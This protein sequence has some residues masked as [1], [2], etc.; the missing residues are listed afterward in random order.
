MLEGKISFAAIDIGSNAVRLL[1]KS[2][3]AGESP[4]QLTKSLLVRVPLR[5]GEDSFTKG[6]ISSTKE[7]R[8]VRLIKS[9]S[10][11]M[12]IYNVTDYR[13][14]ATSAMRDARNGKKIA[15]K[16]FDKTGIRL[17]VIDGLEEARIVYDSHIAD[18][19]SAEGSYLYVDVGGGSTEVSLISRGELLSSHSYNIGTVRALNNRV[20]QE[21]LEAINRD[22]DQLR[23]RYPHLEIIGSGGNINKLYRLSADKK[24][25]A[26]NH[27]SVDHLETLYTALKKLT[28]NERMKQFKLNPDRADVIIPASEIFLN[29][30]HRVGAESIIVPTIG[31]IDGLTHTL[32]TQYLNRLDNR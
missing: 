25:S 5:L 24:A 12:K 19:L 30:A 17:E 8:L 7:K 21:D 9:F 28:L 14:C 1:I 32:Y 10:L 6:E 20:K 13:A 23:E 4:D 27:L 3:Y 29:I 18:L 15:E 16:I 22:M 11:L 31:I 26:E 2:V